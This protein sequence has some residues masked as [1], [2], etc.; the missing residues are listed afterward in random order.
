MH[1]VWEDFKHPM[2][3]SENVPNDNTLRLLHRNA[4]KRNVAPHQYLRTKLWTTNKKMK[5]T[6]IAKRS[7][8]QTRYPFP[9]QQVRLC[10]HLRRLAKLYTALRCIP[11]VRTRNSTL[12]ELSMCMDRFMQQPQVESATTIIYRRLMTRRDC[13]WTRPQW[14]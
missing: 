9:L 14:R 4:V 3:Q 8:K 6:A 7:M 12:S 2:T 13:I 11:N 5:I 1:Q 10:C